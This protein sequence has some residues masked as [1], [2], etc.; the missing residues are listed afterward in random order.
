MVGEGGA[1]G[2][3]YRVE[4]SPRECV[5]VFHSS[6]D[7]TT[8]SVRIPKVKS[9]IDKYEQG[10]IGGFATLPTAIVYGEQTS[11][12][13]I[14]YAMDY[15]EGIL[16]SELAFA[17]VD[18]TFSLEERAR[19]AYQLADCVAHAHGIASDPMTRRI[20]IGDLS[21][22]NAIYQPQTGK[23]RIVDPD[24]FQLAGRT[25]NKMVAYPVTE[26]HTPPT[27]LATRDASSTPHNHT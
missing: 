26:L 12:S 10:E 7:A 1:V 25:G 20:V 18:D 9:L 4:G 15:F 24:S 8:V 14:G 17:D 21:L 16:L 11:D 19:A 23:V 27:A 3:V 5:K 2:N 22:A 13:P 6:T